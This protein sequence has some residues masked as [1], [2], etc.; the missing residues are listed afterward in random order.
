MANTFKLCRSCVH[1]VEHWI[2][3]ND[4][5]RDL[6]FGRCARFAETHPITGKTTAPYAT[7]TRVYLCRGKFYETRK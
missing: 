6:L 1:F 4:R 5:S 3:T 7:P 2:R